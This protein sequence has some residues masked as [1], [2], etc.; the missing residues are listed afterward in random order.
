LGLL[1][2]VFVTESNA[3][4]IREELLVVINRGATALVADMTAAYS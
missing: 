1:S 2:G 4:Q 3:G